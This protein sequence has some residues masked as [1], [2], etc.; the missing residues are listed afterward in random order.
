MTDVVFHRLRV[1]EVIAET[2]EAHSLVFDPPRGR[3]EPLP[4]RPGQFLTLRIPSERCGSVARAYSL[5]SS[6]HVDPRLQVTVKRTPDG[7]ASNWIC[8]N[9]TAGT[10]LDVLEPAGVFTPRSLEENLLL[11]AAGS[12]ITPIMSIV[13]SSLT[14]GSGRVVLIYANRDERSVI[15]AGELSRLAEAHPDR[16]VV[17]HWLESVQG[18]PTVAGLRGLLRPFTDHEA[19]ICGPKPFMSAVRTALREEGVPRERTHLERFASLGGNPFE[20][21]R[22]ADGTATTGTTPAATRAAENGHA[23]TGSEPDA[24]G[25]AATDRADGAAVGGRTATVEVELDG[26]RHTLPWPEGKPLLDLMREHGLDAPFSCTEGSCGACTCRVTEGEVRMR[27]N[28]VLEDEDLAEGYVLACQA[29][30]VT[31]AV[32]VD[33]G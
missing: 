25:P 14:A 16:L 29:L 13:K 6:P 26:E 15:F 17:V 20:S 24:A 23:D 33:Y 10:E 7:Y 31:D 28:Q 2:A 5:S 32:R 12:G 21:A 3:T 27:R 19:F 18:L 22:P 8:D 4:Y 30:P 11:F 9:V 1:A